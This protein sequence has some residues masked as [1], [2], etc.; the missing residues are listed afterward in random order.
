MS[1]GRGARDI[2]I[3]GDAKQELFAADS[4]ITQNKRRDLESVSTRSVI[5][6]LGASFV[7]KDC[8]TNAL[9]Q[10]TSVDVVMFIA[11]IVIQKL[12]LILMQNHG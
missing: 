10:D 12:T 9:N 1:I 5:L 6:S 2:L 8:V 3:A 4:A 11:K 7:K